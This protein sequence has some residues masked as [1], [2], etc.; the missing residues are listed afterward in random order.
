MAH[1]CRSVAAFVKS[2]QV[3]FVHAG[4]LFG[5]QD[6]E[7]GR[8]AIFGHP[9]WPLDPLDWN[10]RQHTAMRSLPAAA[11]ARMFDLYTVT[12]WPE[13]TSSWLMRE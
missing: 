11:T 2:F 3:E 12:G 4:D 1:A 9:M 5:A 13:R 7:T 10:D 6:P 8:I